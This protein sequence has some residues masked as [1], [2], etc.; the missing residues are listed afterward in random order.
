VICGFA[1][2]CSVK[3]DGFQVETPRNRSKKAKKKGFYLLFF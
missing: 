3:M 2:R 1:A